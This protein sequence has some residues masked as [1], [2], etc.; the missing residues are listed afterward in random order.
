MWTASEG[1]STLGYAVAA[2][3][4]AIVQRCF[5]AKEAPLTGRSPN[6]GLIPHTNWEKCSRLWSGTSLA[7]RARTSA[8][9]GSAD[10]SILCKHKTGRFRPT[11]RRGTWWRQRGPGNAAACLPYD[12]STVKHPCACCD[13]HVPTI[14]AS[15][16]TQASSS[17][18]G[19]YRHAK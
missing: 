11:A 13:R 12:A 16:A 4:A 19:A 8:Q 14:V 5:G 18:C 9:F 7:R 1:R 6:L 3:R 10:K 15:G 17:I 2:W